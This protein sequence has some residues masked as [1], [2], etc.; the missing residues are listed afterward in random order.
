[1]TASY[2]TS[3]LRKKQRGEDEDNP[4]TKAGNNDVALTMTDLETNPEYYE[5]IKAYMID[6]KGKH[7]ARKN[8]EE[9]VTCIYHPIELPHLVI[10][11]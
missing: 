10:N 6:R 2:T 3:V 1:M 4:Q 11:L 8:P 9:V 5:P 7:F